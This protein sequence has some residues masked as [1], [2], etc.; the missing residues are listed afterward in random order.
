MHLTNYAINKN[1]PGFEF[2][3]DAL[4]ADTGSKRCELMMM[5]YLD[6]L[7][8]NRSL[9]SINRTLRKMGHDVDAMW[10]RIAVWILLATCLTIAYPLITGCRDQDIG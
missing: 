8:R 10:D 5:M 3:T 7:T 6:D 9:E 4:N 2:N 1:N